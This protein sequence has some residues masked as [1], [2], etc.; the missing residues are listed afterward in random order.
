MSAPC[1]RVNVHRRDIELPLG[2]IFRYRPPPGGGQI[3]VR[4]LWLNGASYA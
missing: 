3:H 4:E 1:R 2:R